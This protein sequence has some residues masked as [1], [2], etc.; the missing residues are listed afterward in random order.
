MA[1]TGAQKFLKKFGDEISRKE[2][3]VFN[4]QGY[5]LDLLPKGKLA[6]GAAARVAAI[7]ESSPDVYNT[8]PTGTVNTD[9]DDTDEVISPNSTNTGANVTGPTA[10]APEIDTITRVTLQN[11]IKDTETEKQ[12]LY[13]E[14]WAK[15]QGISADATRYVSDREKEAILGKADIETRGRIDLQSIINAGLKDVA[16]IEAQS[17][18]DVATIGGEFGVKQEQT[19]QTGQKDIARIGA[20]AGILQGLVGAFNF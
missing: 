15:A 18:R 5:N 3:N 12:K 14:G 16:G 8:K 20:R 10:T 9:S 13:N 19:R 2:V 6:S 11:I 1:K 4:R 7:K 17:A